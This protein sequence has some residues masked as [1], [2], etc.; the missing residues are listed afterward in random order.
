MVAY[1]GSIRHLPRKRGGRSH[2]RTIL[3][4]FLFSGN[5]AS[6]QEVPEEKREG[7]D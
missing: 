2:F 4:T 6:Q 7:T 1:L 3:E 5:R